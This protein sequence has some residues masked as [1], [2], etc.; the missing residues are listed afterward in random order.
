MNINIVKL[1]F[2]SAQGGANA[3]SVCR[4]LT[5][6]AESAETATEKRRGVSPETMSVA[7]TRLPDLGAS[8]Q[9]GCRLSLPASSL[10]FPTRW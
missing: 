10:W 5:D 3:S 4:A 7:P 1:V 9:A 8:S 6:G 2:V